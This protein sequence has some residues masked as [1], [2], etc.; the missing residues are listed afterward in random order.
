VALRLIYQMSAKLLS[1]IV[2]QARS[3]TAKE[4]EILVLRHQ[5]AVLQRRTP[6]PRISWSDRAV[7]AALGRLLPARRRRGFLVTP[8]TI[9][10]WHRQLV[11]RRWTTR[12]VQ[13]G[14][15]A[16]PAGVRAV[17]VRLANENPSWGYRRIHGELAALGYQI[18]A[19]TVWKIL[20]AAGIDPAPRRA[21][22][23]WAQ[24]LRVQAHGIL[25]CDLFHLDT[26]IA[27]FQPRRVFASV[28]ASNR[29]D[30]VR[31]LG[32]NTALR[33]YTSSGRCVG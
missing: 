28:V 25:A 27:G 29:Q 19:S 1:W 31:A 24:F 14:R 12:P 5:L 26:I 15:P 11:R 32:R 3:D 33:R 13:A 4:I 10:R 9:L 20:N 2:L 17:I 21:G 16:I 18:G 8:A 7:I 30:A 6:R 22:P 23:T